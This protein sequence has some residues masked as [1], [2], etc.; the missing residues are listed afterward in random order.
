MAIETVDDLVTQ[1]ANWIGVYGAHDPDDPPAEGE[2]CVCR[3]CFESSMA[4]RI[5]EAVRIENAIAK[6]SQ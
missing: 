4:S 1:I 2:D 5:R 3:C 6:G